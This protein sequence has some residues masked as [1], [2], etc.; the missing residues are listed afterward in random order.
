MYESYKALAQKKCP[1]VIFAGRLG[2]Y[3]YYDMDVA[4]MRV[5]ELVSENFG[6]A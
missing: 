2:E 5:L 1:D 4:V 6:R 3:K